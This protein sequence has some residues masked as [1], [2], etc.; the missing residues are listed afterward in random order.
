MSYSVISLWLIFHLNMN[1][2]PGGSVIQ[3]T[4]VDKDRLSLLLRVMPCATLKPRLVMR[5]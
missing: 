5:T 3:H 2:I 4:G 1:P